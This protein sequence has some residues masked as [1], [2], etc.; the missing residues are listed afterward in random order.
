MSSTAGRAAI[1]RASLGLTHEQHRALV[2]I[3]R[4]RLVRLLHLP[5]GGSAELTPTEQRRLRNRALLSTVRGLTMLG[6]GEIASA[7]LREAPH[8]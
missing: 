5:F 3:Y 4:A 8:E 7:L 6:E 1:S 2:D